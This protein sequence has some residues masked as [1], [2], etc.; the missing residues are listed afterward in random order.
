MASRDESMFSVVSRD[1]SLLSMG[2]VGNS[3]NSMTGL[4]RMSR[5]DSFPLVA[6]AAS[7]TAAAT[8]VSDLGGKSR[9]AKV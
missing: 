2:G 5:M 9:F 7:F 3:I 8:S 4:S 1:A 6:P